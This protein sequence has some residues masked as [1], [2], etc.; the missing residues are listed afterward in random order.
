[1]KY[2]ILH[3]LDYVCKE[4]YKLIEEF[5]FA[6]L[7]YF[8]LMREAFSYDD[9][10]GYF[11][12]TVF[13]FQINMKEIWVDATTTTFVFINFS[14]YFYIAAVLFLKDMANLDN[15]FT[16]MSFS[17]WLNTKLITSF[18]FCICIQTILFIPVLLSG[19]IAVSFYSVLVK[20]ALVI[21]ILIIYLYFLIIFFHK[22]KILFVGM[23]LILGI[24][25]MYPL[26]I[27]KQSY[28]HL[29]FALVIEWL[30]AMFL[31]RKIK[32]SDVK[33]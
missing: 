23:L 7:L 15:L 4:K 1:M 21:M 30:F 17:R 28:I 9:V 6:M 29:C 14:I 26:D 19:L 12:N 2:S 5:L 13:G 18:F 11:L 25:G 22:N 33:E 8:F 16:R 24:F 27:S 10:Y 20:K 32:F 31:C 3:D